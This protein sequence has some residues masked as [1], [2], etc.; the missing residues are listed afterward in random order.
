MRWRLPKRRCGG[1]RARGARGLLRRAGRGPRRRRRGRQGEHLLSM[2]STRQCSGRGGCDLLQ[3]GSRAGDAH[4]LVLLNDLAPRTGAYLKKP[5]LEAAVR[6]PQPAR[7]AHD[8]IGAGVFGE[9]TPKI[10]DRGIAAA[11]LAK[12]A[13][14]G[15]LLVSAVQGPPDSLG[16][17]RADLMLGVQG[18]PQRLVEFARLRGAQCCS[19]Y[20]GAERRQQRRGAV[21]APLHRHCA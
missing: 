11:P 18:A 7:C 15:T 3:P 2:P 9:G 4:F 17:L 1:C 13:L 8:G 19:C 6:P 10:E 14:R 5:L 16:C 12:A 20:V 21:A